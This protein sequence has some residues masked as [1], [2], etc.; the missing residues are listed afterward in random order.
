MKRMWL[1]I[2]LLGLFL[3]LGLW[4]GHAMERLHDPIAHQLE[5]AA[6]TALQGDLSSALEIAELARKTWDS[7]W[8]STAVVADHAPMDEIDAHFARLPV[9]ASMSHQADF[10]ACCAQ[11]AA[12]ITAT[13]EAHAFSWWNIL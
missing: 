11:L 1:G 4:S 5:Q 13:A 7:K 3:G 12:L 9:Y 6:E 8:H 10:A 2:G